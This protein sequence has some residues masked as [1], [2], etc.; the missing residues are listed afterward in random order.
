MLKFEL[1]FTFNNIWGEINAAAID[2]R[3]RNADT[4]LS[5]EENNCSVN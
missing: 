1:I 5:R 4:Y 2:S 3:L